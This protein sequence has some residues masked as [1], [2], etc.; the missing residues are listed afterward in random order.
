MG[1]PRDG[2]GPRGGDGGVLGVMRW[3]QGRR[4]VPP[5]MGGCPCGGGRVPMM[6]GFSVVMGGSQGSWG[7]A[8]RVWGGPRDVGGLCWGSQGKGKGGPGVDGEVRGEIEGPSDHGDCP[9]GNWGVPGRMGGPPALSGVGG[10]T[11][12]LRGRGVG[13]MG[14]RGDLR[15]PGGGLTSAPAA[16]QPWRAPRPA[17]PRAPRAAS[18]APTAASASGWGGRQGGTQ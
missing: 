3:S 16:A 2:G 10:D 9:W 15:G 12:A 18:P 5:V 8:L 13:G 6:L 1:G 7:G 4:R 11:T 14:D 17:A